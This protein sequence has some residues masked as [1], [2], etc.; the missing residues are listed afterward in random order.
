MIIYPDFLGD[1]VSFIKTKSNRL[2][3][4]SLKIDQLLIYFFCVYMP[5]DCN[6]LHNLN[7]FESIINEISAICITNNV[8]FLCLLGDMNTDFLRTQS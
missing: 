7:E 8:E 1:K 5:W 6:E 2:C 4:M 3:S